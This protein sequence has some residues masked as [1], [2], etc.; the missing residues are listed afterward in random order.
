MRNRH[1]VGLGCGESP[2]GPHFRFPV[3]VRQPSRFEK[4][5]DA[6]SLISKSNFPERRWE[7]GLSKRPNSIHATAGDILEKI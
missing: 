6:F 4:L 5:H 1:A 3:S 2:A 7:A